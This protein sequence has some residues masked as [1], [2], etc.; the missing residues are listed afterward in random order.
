MCSLN[1]QIIFSLPQGYFD[2]FVCEKIFWTFLV[3]GNL[4]CA[5]EP[6][7]LRVAWQTL[8]QKN[9][10]KTPLMR[11]WPLQNIR[12]HNTLCWSHQNF[13]KALFLGVILTPKRNWRQCLFKIL[14][15]PIKS[16]MVSYCPR[17]DFAQRRN[18]EEAYLQFK[19][20]VGILEKI[21]IYSNR[22]REESVGNDDVSIV[23]ARKYEM[24][25]M[26]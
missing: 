21:S 6:G 14:K 5:K 17:R 12:Y 22:G 4:S 25:R 10:F 26:T 15:W 11:K 8:I 1:S 24:V 16:I 19:Y 13:A 20:T 3:W 18:P 9:K 23:C 2:G 7:W